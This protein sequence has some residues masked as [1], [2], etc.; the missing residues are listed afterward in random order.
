MT[1][2]RRPAL[3]VAIVGGGVIGCFLAYRLALEGVP[4]GVLERGEL[5]S[6]ASGASAGN[7]QPDTGGGETFLAGLGVESLALYRLYLPDIKQD[8]GMDPLDQDVQYLYAAFN[9]KEV[10]ETQATTDQLAK[11]GLAVEWVDRKQAR[12]VEPRLSEGI[13][14]GMLHRDCIQIEPGR[15]V[16]AL[17]KAA[18]SHGAQIIRADVIGMEVL[19]DRVTGVKCGDG[20]TIPCNS[21]VIATGAWS[22]E[23][24]SSWLGTAL[25]IGPDGMQK[26]HLRLEGGPLKCAVRWQGINM[27]HRRD[28]LIHLGSKHDDTGFEV[29]PTEEGESWLLDVLSTPF[30]GLAV[31][32]A[33][34]GSGCGSSTPGR[35]PLLGSLEGYDGV[36]LAVP[37]TNGFLLA[38][39]IADILTNLLVH[40]KEHPLLSQ[41]SPGEAVARASRQ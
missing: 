19:G 2:S 16:R 34:T 27:V 37:S 40:G 17:A 31:Q 35:V 38:A 29:R 21:L 41:M 36:Y 7:V 28:G 9:D 14:G 22:R 26:L 12:D 5:A 32:V 30:P 23:C 8:S 20:R 10:G 1:A 3:D 39:V 18:E 15:F 25:P 33:D 24:L 4:V 6:G 13:L 11:E